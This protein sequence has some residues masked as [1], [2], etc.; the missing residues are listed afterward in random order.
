MVPSGLKEPQSI[1]KI[2]SEVLAR[3]FRI[4]APAQSEKCSSL[5]SG[6]L[7]KRAVPLSAHGDIS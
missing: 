4:V 6:L 3:E 2:S 7:G 5:P 1:K